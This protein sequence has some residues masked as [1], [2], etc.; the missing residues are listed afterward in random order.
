M[1]TGNT[2]GN[3]DDKLGYSRHYAQRIR[4]LGKTSKE[5]WIKR[6]W[7]HMF[8]NVITPASSE[9]TLRNDRSVSID[10]NVHSSSD[11]DTATITGI[12]SSADAPAAVPASS[13]KEVR[14][15]ETDDYITST[16]PTKSSSEYDNDASVTS[17][18]R[19]SSSKERSVK[20]LPSHLLNSPYLPQKD[21]VV[22]YKPTV[23]SKPR[24]DA[25]DG[26]AAAKLRY[27]KLS[28]SKVSVVNLNNSSS[29]PNVRT[30][31]N[32]FGNYGRQNTQLRSS[33]Q[34]AGKPRDNIRSRMVR[35]PAIIQ[36]EKKAKAVADRAAKVSSFS[37]YVCHAVDC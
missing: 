2:K 1:A 19:I 4:D 34:E 37:H 29:M 7:N 32:N 30:S 15:A 10:K 5:S 24:E 31:T 27:Q 6:L 26:V 20:S 28:S 21:K 8:G 9:E 25:R 33:T 36:L 16:S 35:N 18:Q 22:Y 11:T 17:R 13:D 3:P 14:F 23:S 12:D